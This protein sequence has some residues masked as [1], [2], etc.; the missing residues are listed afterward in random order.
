MTKLRETAKVE[1]SWQDWEKRVPI[2]N[3]FVAAYDSVDLKKKQI[4]ENLE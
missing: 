3:I 1:A 2:Y 4:G